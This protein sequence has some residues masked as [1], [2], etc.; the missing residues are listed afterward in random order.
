MKQ[1]QSSQQGF[2]LIASLSVLAIILILVMMSATVSLRSRTTNAFES[3]KTQAFYVAQ[4]G[5]ERAIFKA[6]RLNNKD[7]P[8]TVT[9]N[10]QAAIWVASQLNGTTGTLPS[11]SFTVS[12]SVVAGATATDP[13]KIT[14][15]SEGTTLS[16]TSVR[17]VSSAFPVKINL[18]T[19]AATSP[20]IASAPGCPDDH[21][22][23]RHQRLSPD[24][25]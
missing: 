9:T 7:L 24:C 10:E 8:A 12:T 5:L 21:R 1:A 2:A 13:A 14:V 18:T 3:R 25:W 4:S 15:V 23:Q 17:R 19:P 20:M 6:V 22:Q 16:S 11:G